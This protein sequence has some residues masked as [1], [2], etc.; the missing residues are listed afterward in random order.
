M[1]AGF[2]ATQTWLAIVDR[3]RI[4]P[5]RCRGGRGAEGIGGVIGGKLLIEKPESGLQRADERY[6]P[7]GIYYFAQ[8]YHATRSNF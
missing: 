7:D 2:R 5:R 3:A 4:A 8:V 6:P 1:G